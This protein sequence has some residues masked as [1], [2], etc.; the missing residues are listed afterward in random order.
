ML[1][2]TI[3]RWLLLTLIAQKSRI[4]TFH[5][6]LYSLAKEQKRL[7]LLELQLW[8]Q[9]RQCSFLALGYWFW[10]AS[11]FDMKREKVPPPTICQS[12]KFCFHWQEREGRT[13]MLMDL[14]PLWLMGCDANYN[15]SPKCT[16]GNQ[17][18]EQDL[19]DPALKS[20]FTWQSYLSWLTI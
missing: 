3:W 12:L 6:F 8:V 9:N 5:L 14:V 1:H 11:F 17:W 18:G 20:K 10:H 2:N 7:L 16:Y 15:D 4:P 13:N 19:Y